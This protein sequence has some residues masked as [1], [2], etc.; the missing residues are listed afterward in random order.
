M[1][2]SF[3]ELAQAVRETHTIGL[4][5]MARL[6]GVAEPDD[7][8]VMR[9]RKARLYEVAELL[10]EQSPHE[11]L[12]RSIMRA[13]G[14]A[15]LPDYSANLSLLATGVTGLWRGEVLDVMP[16]DCEVMFPAQRQRT[17]CW[18]GRAN[19]IGI[20]RKTPSMWLRAGSEPPR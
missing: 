4:Q 14:L 16:M 13:G 11:A 20:E 12:I 15:E 17:R 5:T 2:S 1:G 3:T 8:E 9:A 10:T 7:L 6:V 18:I 19:L